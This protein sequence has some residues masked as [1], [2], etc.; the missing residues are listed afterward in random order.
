MWDNARSQSMGFKRCEAGLNK[1]EAPRQRPGKTCYVCREFLLYKE[2]SL[3]NRLERAVFT[4]VQCISVWNIIV[5]SLIYTKSQESEAKQMW[6][7]FVSVLQMLQRWVTHR[8]PEIKRWLIRVSGLFQMETQSS[9]TAARLGGCFQSLMT[10]PPLLLS[11][12]FNP[13][14][15]S[16]VQKGHSSALI[17]TKYAR[18][19]WIK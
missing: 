18:Q 16:N 6:N 10:S 3:F 13:L 17:G 12:C 19:I 8:G 7:G 14:A 5:A 4:M 9:N 11:L 1:M 15:L 2:N